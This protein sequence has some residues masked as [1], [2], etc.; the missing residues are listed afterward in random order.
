MILP[1]WSEHSGRCAWTLS[2]QRKSGA[3][4]NRRRGGLCE[5]YFAPARSQ[6][7]PNRGDHAAARRAE[8]QKPTSHSIFGQPLITSAE[9]EHTPYFSYSREH[10]CISN[11]AHVGCVV[12]GR[13]V[14][15]AGQVQRVQAKNSQIVFVYGKDRNRPLRRGHRASL[16]AIGVLLYLVDVG[17]NREL[18]SISSVSGGSLTNAYLAQWGE[19]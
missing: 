13:P 3:D 8:W 12:Q 4:H 18:C 14:E 11:A 16:F 17:K 7:C 2:A 15:W 6:P 1:N 10:C 5:S 19:I 9:L